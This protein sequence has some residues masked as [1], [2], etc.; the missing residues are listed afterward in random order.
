VRRNL[1]REVEFEL[2][3]GLNF[4]GRESSGIK[5]PAVLNE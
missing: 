1:R 5:A 3:V 2:T 4:E